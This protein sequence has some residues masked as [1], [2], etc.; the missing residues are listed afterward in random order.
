[1]LALLTDEQRMLRDTAAELASEAGILN[2]ADLD[3]VDRQRAWRSICEAGLLGLRER[4]D[5]VPAASGVEVM[6]VV[7]AL[8]V[9]L[10][11]VPVVSGVLALELLSLAGVPADW[12]TA[13]ASGGARYAVLLSP[14]MLRPAET[15]ELSAV[16]WD[17][18][19]ADYLLALDR[20]PAGTFVTRL[21]ADGIRALDGI[22][23]TRKTCRLDSQVRGERAGIALGQGQLDRWLALALTAI[24]ADIVGALRAALDR[25]VQYSLERFQFGVAI[26]TFQAVQHLCAEALVKVEG[27]DSAAK[28]AAWAIDE[29]PPAEA[30]LAARTAKA[31]ASSVATGVPETVMQVYGGIGQTWENVAHLYL[32]RSL[33]DRQVL[34]NEHVQL[35]AISDS[36]LGRR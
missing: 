9:R 20:S 33:L 15:G 8:S 30:L 11:P 19:D 5:G 18:S 23:L 28:F 4:A 26:G 1:V 6:L 32:R 29:L 13:L 36:R 22:D 17:S 7:Q 2:P 25:V 27:A 12:T 35:A 3:S 24:S 31:Y 34:G 14:D 10:V 16:A 21:A